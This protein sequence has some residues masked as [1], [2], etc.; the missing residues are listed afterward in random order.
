VKT[1]ALHA[2]E[3]QTRAPLRFVLNYATCCR[4][5][6]EANCRTALKK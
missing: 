3:I 1:S 5:Q 2:D 4:E 6:Q